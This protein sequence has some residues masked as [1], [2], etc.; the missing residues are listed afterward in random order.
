MATAAAL[1]ASVALSGTAIAATPAPAP[2]VP[3]PSVTVQQY[4]GTWKQIADIPQFYEVFCT[5]NVTAQYSLNPNGTVAVHNTCAGPFGTTIV[6]DGAARV[7]DTTSNAQLQVSFINLFGTQIFSGTTPNYVIIGLAT[8]YSWAVVGDPNR[9]SAYVL[10]RT[11]TLSA[12]KTAE[13]KAALV[14]SGYD[15]CSLKTTIQDGGLSKVV[16]FC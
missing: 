10:S 6:T 9:A 3:V 11:A 12:A 8:D 15:P 14:R 16:P 4:L 2:I 13:A 1:T 7:L 5:K